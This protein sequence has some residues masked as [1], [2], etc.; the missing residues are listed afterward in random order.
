MK[1]SADVSPQV[2]TRSPRI[3]LATTIWR[4]PTLSRIVLSH[5]AM[6]RGSLA[7]SVDL[8][9]LAA[10]SEGGRSRSLCLENGF[11][12][13]EHRNKPVTAKWNAVVKR[14]KEFDPDG[15][16][17][18]NSD[19]LI[20]G[21]FFPAAAGK[22]AEGVDFFGFR[23][24][25][26]IDLPSLQVG[27]WPGYDSTFKKFRAGE[28]AGCGRC[29]SRRLLEETG[30]RLWADEPG[31]SSS[32]D[33][34]NTRFLR[35]FGFEP[36]AF[37]MSGLGASAV[38]VKS[39]VNITPFNALSIDSLSGNGTAWEV[40]GDFVGGEQVS[41]LKK[42]HRVLRESAIPGEP[43]RRRNA[44]R[45][46]EFRL[47][48]YDRSLF[49]EVESM[50]RRVLTE[51]PDVHIRRLE[52]MD[53]ERDLRA[54]FNKAVLRQVPGVLSMVPESD[55]APGCLHDYLASALARNLERAREN[56]GRELC[57]KYLAWH[58]A[59]DLRA[60]AAAY[61]KTDD[62]RFLRLLAETFEPVLDLRDP[63]LGKRDDVRGRTVNSWGSSRY[64][65]GSGKWMANEVLAGMIL[66]P[67][68]LAARIAGERSV[69]GRLRTSM[70]RFHE[71]ARDVLTEFE[72]C[73]R[74]GPG[75]GEGHYYDP[76]L[77]DTA[78]LNHMLALGSVHVEMYRL[79]GDRQ[80]RRKAE[81]MGTF[82]RNSMRLQENGS[83]VW[84]YHPG[85]ISG[86]KS[87]VEDITHAQ[88]NIHFAERAY[89]GGIV[90][91][92]NDMVRLAATAGK[93]ILRQNGGWAARIDGSGRLCG[94]HEGLP[95]W[96]ILDEF[97]PACRDGIRNALAGRPDLFP[98][99]WFSYAT[100]PIAFAHLMEGR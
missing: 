28:P 52:K 20:A 84:D 100:G 62:A 50:R 79:T 26:V 76:Y 16:V 86:G 19:D 40:L 48:D 14:A 51:L 4:R 54:R 33:F 66:F 68:V 37:T 12:Y 27:V 70:I 73:W 1:R 67:A 36:I 61:E 11:E 18:V 60:C 29:Y 89:R 35:L 55:D 65:G 85:K 64:T 39:D 93:N 21:D 56:A 80:Y 2:R 8:V 44:G 3:V 10:G 7:G 87:P 45:T 58:L 46:P 98:L 96:I 75:D 53:R 41:G 71:A 9:L 57:A 34:W 47:E 6:L 97:E 49:D 59:Y 99:G 72:D 69:Q 82:F 95:G 78:P 43:Y 23:D 81:L 5:Y 22:L 38:Q 90:F 63:V 83:Y 32:M 77:E 17:L 92:R 13:L 30:W 24:T 94:S 15:I 88:V 91:D 42:M 31:K 25:W 74:E